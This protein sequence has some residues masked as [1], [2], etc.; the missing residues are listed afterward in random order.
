MILDLYENDSKT[1]RVYKE[2][3]RKTHKLSGK[4]NPVYQ[5]RIK[6][7][8]GLPANR[9]ST[10][11]T[12]KRL[13]IRHAEDKLNQIIAL[14]AQGLSTSSMR[15]RTV[16]DRYLKSLTNE[17]RINPDRVSDEKLDVHERCIRLHFQELMDKPIGTIQAKTLNDLFLIIE[18]KPKDSYSSRPD[19]KYQKKAVLHTGRRSASGMNKM[20]QVM[21]AIFKY[22]RDVL[23]IIK[24][25]PAI[26]P[27]TDTLDYQATL[28]RL[29]WERVLNY[30]DQEFVK[31]LD[32]KKTDQTRPK[33]YRQSFV[34]WSK[35]VVWTGLRKSE[36]L[37]LQWRDVTWEEDED[38]YEYC[39]IKVA[40][41][42]K[43]ARK[44]KDR[45]FR[46]DL[47]VYDLLMDRKSRVKHADLRDYI[48]T[49]FDDRFG[50][51]PDGR[52][53]PIADMRGTFKTAMTNLKL[54][55][56]EKGKNRVPYQWRHLH[57]QL[58]RQAGKSLD[59]IAEDIGNRITTTERYYVGRGQGTRKGR[60]IKI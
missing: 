13:A 21:R 26:K 5:F 29:D 22:S 27:S 1:L 40:G 30:L 56:D 59:D 2:T 38:G 57:A 25:I 28:S 17:N 15:F 10:G 18:Q 33:Y 48:F 12:N 53:R 3:Y 32:A 46:C 41:F 43:L 44:T 20:K 47:Q 6:V 55:K 49:H 16:C 23:N 35:L 45:K 60:P 50:L 54:Y 9:A 39:L 4:V 58:S 34:D 52:M 31:E 51:L 19:R 14:D 37:K 7:K 36:A 24:D 8:R 11:H 42:E